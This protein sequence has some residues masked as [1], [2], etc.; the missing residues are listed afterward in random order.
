M[1][2]QVDDKRPVWRLGA[3][4]FDGPHGWSKCSSDATVREVARKLAQFETQTWHEI[5]GANSHSVE[6]SKLDLAARNRLAELG[7]EDLE[8]LFSLRL[9]GRER[10]WGI[11]DRW[12]FHVLWW[13]SPVPRL[14]HLGRGGEAI[15]STQ[16]VVVLG[17][18]LYG[19]FDDD[20][21]IIDWMLAFG[22]QCLGE[23][24]EAS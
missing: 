23:R 21:E 8:N 1:P 18:D 9:S 10:V 5:E 19:L 24:K 13:D 2:P 12:I 3:L 4:D 16:D 14:R 15:M 20:D 7:R 11:R 22:R 6:T 17:K